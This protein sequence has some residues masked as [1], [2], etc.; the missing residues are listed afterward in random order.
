VNHVNNNA[1]AL[2]NNGDGTFGAAAHFALGR[3][4]F[5]VCADDFNGDGYDDLA[6]TQVDGIAVLLSNGDGALAPALTYA[7]AD[8]PNWVYAWDLDRDGDQDLVATDTGPK[9]VSVLMN[10]GDGTFADAVN[11]DGGGT[12]TAAFRD[13]S[14]DGHGDLLTTNHSTGSISILLN[15]RDGTFTNRASVK[16]GMFPITIF[17]DDFDSDGDNDIMTVIARRYFTILYN[18]L[19]D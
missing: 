12:G 19:N 18:Q 9:D 7:T 10:N 17:S 2:L 5:S 11:Y 8:D 13:V 16:V 15:N 3:P 1:S 14:G 4:I 6:A